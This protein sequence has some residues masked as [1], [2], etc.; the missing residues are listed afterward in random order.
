MAIP[1]NHF[2]RSKI[3]Y[4]FITNYLY[5]LH[6]II[7]LAS[8]GVVNNI[9]DIKAKWQDISG[10]FNIDDNWTKNHKEFIEKLKTNLSTTPLIGKLSPYS[11]FEKANIHVDI[12]ELAEDLWNNFKYLLPFQLKASGILLIAAYE[13]S[14][15]FS[16]KKPLWEFLRHCRNAAAHNGF[17][18]F[19][20][21]EPSRPAQWGEFQINATMQGT[22][23]FIGEGKDGPG[24]LAIGDPIR[25]LWDIEQSYPNMKA[26]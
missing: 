11:K 1:V 13:S 12:D 16:D 23:L 18:N 14:K 5:S 26:T 9:K 4:P 6:G 25:L 24:L 15:Q 19:R 21:G 3:F 17:F 2:D 8:R 7:E 22:P 20:K 10:V